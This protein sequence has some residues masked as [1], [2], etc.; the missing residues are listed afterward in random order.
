MGDNVSKYTGIQKEE[1]LKGLVHD[2][3]FSQ[4]G[5]EPDIDKRM[6]MTK[7]YGHRRM[8]ESSLCSLFSFSL[9]K[10]YGF[11]HRGLR[12]F[13]SLLISIEPVPKLRLVKAMRN[14]CGQKKGRFMLTGSCF[15]HVPRHPAYMPRRP[16]HVRNRP[17]RAPSRLVR[18][19]NR[20]CVLRNTFWNGLDFL[21]Q[22]F[23]NRST[24]GI[25]KS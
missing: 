6:G 21:K 16:A 15:A 1:T 7:R 8:S 5:Y 4:F 12:F 2:D 25:I 22:G 10:R 14:R 13:E 24:R 20:L 17:V 19:R 23:G 9:I 18:V 11:S 3:F